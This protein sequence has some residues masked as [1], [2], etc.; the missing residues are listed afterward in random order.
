MKEMSPEQAKFFAQ[1]EQELQTLST[2]LTH[3]LPH[4]CLV[5]YVFRMLDFGCHGQYWM[6]RYR[7]LRAPRAT[8]L[9]ERIERRGGYCDCE[10]LQNAFRPNPYLFASNEEGDILLDPMPACLGVRGGSTQPC[11]LWFTYQTPR[12]CNSYSP[13]F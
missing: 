6:V 5:C 2:V 1:V 8:A 7:D 10:M 12:W 13:Y 11:G 9:L 3:P 4:E